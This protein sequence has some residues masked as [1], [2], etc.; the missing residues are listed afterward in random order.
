[1]F[2]DELS[3]FLNELTGHPNGLSGGAHLRTTAA[4]PV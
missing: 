1:M 4:E 3:P 2:L